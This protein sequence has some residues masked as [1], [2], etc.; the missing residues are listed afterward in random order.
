M[1]REYQQKLTREARDEA[2]AKA[3]KQAVMLRRM[4]KEGKSAQQ[5][6]AAIAKEA[7]I[8]VSSS[9]DTGSYYNPR[10]GNRGSDRGSTPEQRVEQR[11]QR[12]PVVLPQSLKDMIAYN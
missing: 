11:K 8:V 2:R 7:A 5:I 10:G 3:A 12:G 9:E 6:K 1:Q 4:Q